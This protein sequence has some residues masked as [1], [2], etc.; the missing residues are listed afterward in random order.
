MLVLLLLAGTVNYGVFVSPGWRVHLAVA[1]SWFD[2]H[3]HHL[4][5]GIQDYFLPNSGFSALLGM[6]GVTTA[7]P[8]IAIHFLIAI[9]ALC[10]PLLTRVARESQPTTQ[11][12][13]LYLV[14]GPLL[15]LTFN[16][17]GG[18]DGLLLLGLVLGTLGRNP[19]I[20]AT[21]WLLAGL[22]HSE[23]ALLG[24]IGFFLVRSAELRKQDLLRHITQFVTPVIM[25]LVGR[26]VMM[27]IT[28]SWGGSTS[29]AYLLLEYWGFGPGFESFM[30]MAPMILFSSVGALWFILLSGRVLRLRSSQLLVTLVVTYSLVLPIFGGGDATRIVGLALAPAVI[31]WISRLP[32][33]LGSTQS[34]KLWRTYVVAAIIVPAPMITAGTIYTAGWWSFLAFRGTIS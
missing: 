34:T 33:L 4:I 25:I 24:V 26:V 3:S 8:W 14:G 6:L 7:T 21:G 15:A 28:S 18:Y 19:I 30:R 11:L 12:L 5:T 22:S 1:Q 31:S 29:R 2:P 32:Q 9:A 23:V 17:I 27:V 20:S 16:W 13:F 10:S